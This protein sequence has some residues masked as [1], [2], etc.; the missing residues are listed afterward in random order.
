M[1]LLQLVGLDYLMKI[2]EGS[3]DLII[4]L[5]DGPV[6]F[7][8]PSFSESNIKTINESQYAYCKNSSSLACMHGTFTAGILS[9]K[10]GFECPA[11]CPKCTLLVRPV[12][13]ETS[14]NNNNNKNKQ[15]FLDYY[16]PST[17]PQELANAIIET[18][19]AGAKIINLSLGL[20]NNLL[21]NKQLYEVYHYAAKREV[22]IVIAAGNQGNMGQTSLFN[23]SWVIPVASC[24]NNGNI[25]PESNLGP[26]IGNRGVMAPGENVI[27]TSS[28]GGF[29]ISRGT[30]IAAPFV[31][32]TLALLWSIF[33]QKTAADVRFSILK[34]NK[35]SIMPPL[36][37]AYSAFKILN[38]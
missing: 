27:S 26:T 29:I 18:I 37:D 11:I 35:R 38:K 30:S 17:T 14:N 6:H 23:H 20:A 24:S 34:Q 2:S 33:P 7:D 1:N 15:D 31:T 36:L 8:H 10:R 19:K 12:F 22:L 16:L 28:S 3:P 4:G 21:N 32:G 9:S 5:I 25:S 13:M